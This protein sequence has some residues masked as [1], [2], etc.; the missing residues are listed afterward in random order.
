MVQ[1]AHRIGTDFYGRVFYA[2]DGDQEDVIVSELETLRWEIGQENFQKQSQTS[3]DEQILLLGANVE[4]KN[5]VIPVFTSFKQNVVE[6]E[7]VQQNMKLTLPQENLKEHASAGGNSAVFGLATVMNKFVSYAAL[8]FFC[9]SFCF[10]VGH[11]LL[12]RHS[13]FAPLLNCNLRGRLEHCSIVQIAIFN[14]Q[15]NFTTFPTSLLIYNST[16]Q[17]R[18][19]VLKNICF[20]SGSRFIRSY[21]AFIS[22]FLQLQDQI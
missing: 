9:S 7:N 21:F 17:P 5:V 4:T 16:F 8:I 6:F 19:S 15:P 13:T 11:L 12:G 22:L 1:Y 14:S 2:D 20:I 10:V 18:T 3:A